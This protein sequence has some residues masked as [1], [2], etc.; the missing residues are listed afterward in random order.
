MSS[1]ARTW[2]RPTATPAGNLAN[3]RTFGLGLPNTIVN[4]IVYN[5]AVDVLALSLFGRGAWL[6]YDVTAYFPSATVLRFGLADNDSAPPASFLT[7]G[8]YATRSLEKVG[9]GT[10]TISGTT[11]LHRQHQ[12]AGRPARGQRQSHAAR[13]ASSSRPARC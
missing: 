11:A 4:Q 12:R 13:A 5:P 7:N 10:L 1:T 3:W 6:L 2:R 8:N 9:S